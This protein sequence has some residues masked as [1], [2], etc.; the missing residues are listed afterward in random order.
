MM[1]R[2]VD[3]A[4]VA[5]FP[6]GKG[7]WPSTMAF[8]EALVWAALEDAGL[9]AEGVDILF[10]VEP[11]SDPYLIHAAAL[12]ER[13][14]IAPEHCW[15]YEAGGGA[16]VVMLQAA[17][18]LLMQGRARTAVIVAADL[19]LTGVSRDR[20]VSH[21]ASAGPVHPEFEAPYGPSVPAM[22][23]LAARRYF[24]LYGHD[25]DSLFPIVQHDRRMAADHPNAHLRKPLGRD[26][27]LAA[28]PIADPLRLL[29]CAPV[30]DG[31]AAVVLTAHDAAGAGR[32]PAIRLLGSGGA[33][34]HLHLTAAPS[35]TETAAGLAL[36]RAL[37]RA[38]VG[39]EQ[40]DI[41]LIYDC[42][43]IAMAVSLEDMGL[44][45]RGGAAELFAAGVFGRDGDLP[46]NTHGGLLSHG[47]PARAGG[48]ANLVEAILQLRGA[49]GARQVPDC[50][51]ALVHGMGGV[52][53]T[54]NVAI[55]E[56][57]GR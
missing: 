39:R 25:P 26:D 13:L 40:I 33:T 56:R 53:A 31:G 7:T 15:S 14:R 55:L 52:F 47:H 12:A 4:G 32:H 1:A 45:R 20:Y 27:Y 50:A 41:A 48:V 24:D 21:L 36:E 9:D 23:A 42:F 3:I 35:I 49:A 10:T 28:K 54:H 44:A 30:S 18:D 16:P 22:F 11:R 51:V 57:A 17:H 37:A 5:E 8:S 34:S 6:Q 19:P 2:A 46:V 29:D 38:G 43:S